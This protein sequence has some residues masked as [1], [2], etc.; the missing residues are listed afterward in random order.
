MGARFVR[1]AALFYGALAV[2][3]A[4]WNGLRD[5]EFAFAASIP[6]SLLLGL[7][8]AVATVSLGLLFYLLVPIM[9]QISDELAPTLVDG[10]DKTSFVLISVFSGIGEEMFFRGAVQPEFGLVVAA[11]AFGLVHIGPDR[12]YLVW[13][14]WAILA[15]FLF[16][17]L[18]EL[19][20]GLLAPVVAHAT[21]NA[22]TFLLWK[23]SR[24]NKTSGNE[25]N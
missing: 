19:T 23:Y 16:G 17:F 20:G 25:D 1:Q 6:Q 24:N 5:R 7:L 12:R 11:L 2:A 18:Y 4:I 9:R 21:H 15:G 8:A 14:A 3:A 22:A 10:T 13:T